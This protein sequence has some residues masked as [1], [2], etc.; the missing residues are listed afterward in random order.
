MYAGSVWLIEN[1]LTRMTP[2]LPVDAASACSSPV[3]A[4][5]PCV[6]PHPTV[7]R[8][9]NK[10]STAKKLVF[11]SYFFIFFLLWVSDLRT[12]KMVKAIRKQGHISQLIWDGSNLRKN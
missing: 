3:S 11:F 1:A 8:S 6:P 7:T 4:G 10:A 12:D 9:R 2:C 5:W